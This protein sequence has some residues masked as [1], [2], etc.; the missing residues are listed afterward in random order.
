MNCKMFHFRY[1]S[2]RQNT[3]RPKGGPVATCR[4]NFAFPTGTLLLERFCL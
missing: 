4:Y 1:K 3:D 2:E